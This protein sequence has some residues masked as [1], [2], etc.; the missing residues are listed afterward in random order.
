MSDDR[1]DSR[2]SLP[3]TSHHITE[4][5]TIIHYIADK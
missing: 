4:H 3:Y 1:K 2:T 5:R